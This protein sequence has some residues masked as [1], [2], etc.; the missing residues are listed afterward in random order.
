MIMNEHEQV[1]QVIKKRPDERT[2]DEIVAVL[3]WLRKA[4]SIFRE[5]DKSKL[6]LFTISFS[7]N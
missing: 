4:S 1:I 2:N 5:I 3:P 6:Y 7:S